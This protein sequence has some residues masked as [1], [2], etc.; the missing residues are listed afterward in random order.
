MNALQ[1]YA[2][3]LVSVILILTFEKNEKQIGTALSVLTTCL[4]LWASIMYL[5]PI[6]NFIRQ[7]ESMTLIDHEMFGVLLKVS[8]MGVITEIAN[9]ICTD[10]GNA[11]LGKAVQLLGISIILWLSLPLFS[12]LVSLLQEILGEL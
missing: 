6:I 4:V 10:S 12:S 11:S 2:V 1:I 5:E 3:V 9:L 7:I 8:G